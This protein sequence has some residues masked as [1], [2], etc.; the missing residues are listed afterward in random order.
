MNKH[1]MLQDGF[2]E[3]RLR[4][5]GIRYV[6]LLGPRSEEYG[7][8]RIF[9]PFRVGR[10]YLPDGSKEEVHHLPNEDWVYEVQ[11][12]EDGK[13]VQRYFATLK[14]DPTLHRIS[15]YGA[16]MFAGRRMPLHKVIE[17]HPEMPPIEVEDD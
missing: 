11:R 13:L 17:E 14:N 9:N 3:L 4:C 5:P 12:A 7:F 6:A 15:R 10:E 16:Q 2:I 1:Q 8:E